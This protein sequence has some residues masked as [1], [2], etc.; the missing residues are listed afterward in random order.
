[1]YSDI[2]KGT[3]SYRP[4]PV[5][6][7]KLNLMIFIDTYVLKKATPTGGKDSIGVLLEL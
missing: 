7:P 3:D 5:C 2:S 6:A 4:F 1:M